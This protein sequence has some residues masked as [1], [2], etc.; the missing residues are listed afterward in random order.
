MKF[1]LFKVTNK[2]AFI[3]GAVSALGQVVVSE[4]YRTYVDIDPFAGVRTKIKQ[5]KRKKE[6]DKI[7][8]QTNLKVVEVAQ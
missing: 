1:N 8:A 4:V 3:M 2:E 7:M 6:F 5:K